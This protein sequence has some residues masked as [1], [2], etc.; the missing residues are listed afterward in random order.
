MKYW[1]LFFFIFLIS[2]SY[3]QNIV[4]STK[5]KDI[6][7]SFAFIYDSILKKTYYTD[8]LGII[9]KKYLK[10]N[11]K[12]YCPGFK[13]YIISK[14][15]VNKDTIFLESKSILL[16]EIILKKRE[17][18]EIGNIKNFKHIKDYNLSYLPLNR[19]IGLQ[20][21]ILEDHYLKSVKFYS[22]IKSNKNQR[23]RLRIFRKDESNF[24][25]ILIGNVFSKPVKKGINSIEVQKYLEKGEYYFSLERINS[26][27]DFFVSIGKTKT[28]NSFLNSFFIHIENDKIETFPMNI[29]NK[30][31][32]YELMM[33]IELN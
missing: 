17:I 27:I 31:D 18:S 3:S 16:D 32:N 14:E 9:S 30:N 8:S 4:V 25:E 19:Y 13:S 5:E 33:S 2:S 23:I 26:D 12:L 11:F 6:K 22:S 24:E 21:N 7:V 28:K 10:E 20:Y 1:F 15:D 29:G